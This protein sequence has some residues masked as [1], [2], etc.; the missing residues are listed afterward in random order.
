MAMSSLLENLSQLEPT[1]EGADLALSTWETLQTERGSDGDQ[2]FL[3]GLRLARRI[4][5]ESPTVNAAVLRLRGL[6]ATAQ[7]PTS[8]GVRTKEPSMP[9]SDTPASPRISRPRSPRVPGKR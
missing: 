1:K 9:R 5:A 6:E 2:Q 3:T 4:L 8:E 7:S